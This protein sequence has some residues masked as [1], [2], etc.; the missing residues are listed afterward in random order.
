MTQITKLRVR[1][2]ILEIQ[3]QYAKGNKKELED[4]MRAW[5]GIKELTPDDPKSFFMLGGFHGE[6]FRGEGKTDSA[7]WGGYCM[8]GN[9]LFPTWHRVY[10][11]KLEEALQSIPGCKDV[12]L[13]YW[14]ETDKYSLTKGIPS[15]LT[16]ETF[17]LDGK[18]IP[19]PLRSF[20]MPVA[21]I[22]LIDN[23]SP[24]QPSYSKPKGYETV[25]FPL[26][27]LVGTEADRVA[28]AAYNK[29][30]DK[31]SRLKYLNDNV[32]A[33]LSDT[34]S[35]PRR[36]ITTVNDL[37]KMCLTAPNYTVFSNTTSYAQ[38]NNDNPANTTQPLEQPHNDV[39]ISVGGPNRVQTPP[40]T[41]A[42]GDMGENDTAGLD[43]IFYF[44]HCNV[45]RMFWLWQKQNGFTDH[46]DIIADYPGTKSSDAQGPTPGYSL[47][48]VLDLNSPLY[49]FAKKG[50]LPYPYK[51]HDP[52]D[53]YVSNDC[54]NI[55]KQLNF[56][57]S[58]GSLEKP[59]KSKTEAMTEETPIPIN[60]GNSRK[61]LFVTD[62]N[63]GDIN[64]SFIIAAYITV[65][66]QRDLLGYH[67]VLSRKNVKGCANCL[68][69]LDVA[70]SFRLNN[71]T[72]EELQNATFDVEIHGK[73][74]A[75]KTVFES[76]KNA[77]ATNA[78]P[79]YTLDVI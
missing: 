44:H 12:M 7:Y 71:Y 54:I 45:D 24:Q 50:E 13:P 62:I 21:I 67:S 18:T 70:A 8:H 41:D 66:G 68:T 20:I 9:V 35:N 42:N 63:R 43:P 55:E 19:N 16:D 11:H 52:A 77:A 46:L 58:L 37:Y 6:P 74:A 3:E 60:E 36:P 33:W 72:D 38:Y 15:C 34:G 75:N 76:F 61:Q 73:E 29:Q 47:N 26:S 69:H 31:A 17:I 2:S 56:T 48:S 22:D 51:K 78:I 49:P 65:N 40:V 28:T 32:V 14:D 25:R 57:Y 5:K 53:V 4:L 1:K 23:G 59:A 10:L 30:F 27:G 39:H 64:G 79:A